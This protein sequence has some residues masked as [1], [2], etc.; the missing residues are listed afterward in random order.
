MGLVGHTVLLPQAH[1]LHLTR[2]ARGPWRRCCDISPGCVLCALQVTYN[3]NNPKQFVD[4]NH[5][6]LRFT[7]VVTADPE[8]AGLSAEQRAAV[9]QLLDNGDGQHKTVIAATLQ[10]TRHLLT[11]LGEQLGG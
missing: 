4:Q 3:Y 9:Q 6:A 7:V 2:V 8:A 10:Q 5:A 11:V 1:T